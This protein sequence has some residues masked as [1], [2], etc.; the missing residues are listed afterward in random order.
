MSS[1][2]KIFRLFAENLEQDEGVQWCIEAGPV[3]PLANR[4]LCAASRCRCWY[5]LCVS[6]AFLWLLNIS[7]FA[8]N[9]SKELMCVWFLFQQS[10]LRAKAATALAR[11]SCRNSVCPSIRLSVCLS[12]RWI[13][14]RWCKLGS[15]NL[16]HRLPGRH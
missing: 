8:I 10:F 6:D 13:S 12:H 16:Y 1:L 7:L 11:L 5:C 14:Q 4:R 3:W 2:L 15:S 9:I